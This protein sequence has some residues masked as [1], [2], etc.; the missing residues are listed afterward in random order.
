MGAGGAAPLREHQQSVA[1]R[2]VLRAEYRSLHSATIGEAMACVTTTGALRAVLNNA[3][4]IALHLLLAAGKENLILNGGD[5]L[6]AKLTQLEDLHKKGALLTAA[7]ALL[8][9]TSPSMQPK[10]AHSL[11]RELICVL[12]R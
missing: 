2:R 5:E 4:L 12:N 9:Y 7:A 1:E 6:R 11:Q 10:N 8:T 3:S